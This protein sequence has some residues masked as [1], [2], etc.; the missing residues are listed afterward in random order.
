MP[1]VLIYSMFYWPEESGNGPYSTGL[2]EHLA[3]EGMGVTVVTAMPHYP[4]WQVMPEYRGRWRQTDVRAGVRIERFRHHIP[5]RQSAIRRAMYEGSFLAHAGLAGRHPRPDAVLGVI[6][7]LSGGVLARLAAAR[8]RAA[9][10]IVVQDVMS[11]AAA[12]SGI[13]GGRRV[14]AVTGRIEGW[15]MG[16]ATI[17]APVAA[18]F[19]PF[20]EAMGVD[21]ARIVLLPNWTHLPPPRLERDEVRRELGWEPDD[22]VVLHAGNMGLKQGL[23]QVIEAARTANEVDRRLRF[24]LMGDGNQRSHLEQLAGSLPNVTFLPFVERDRLVE[25]LAAADVLLVS[26]RSTVRDMSLPSK[27]TSYFAAGRPVVAAVDPSGASAAEVHRA[28]GGVVTRAGDASGLVR[29]IIDLDADRDEMQRLGDN[30]RRYAETNLGS[31]ASLARATAIVDRLLERTRE[32]RRV[33]PS[34]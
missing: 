24:V 33:G 20:I 2:A 29:A 10:G 34:V 12:Q 25:V 16:R 4:A 6:P 5:S 1:S 14:A 15:A 31:A 3:A 32:R 19:Q 27:L 17:V 22:V 28:A 9:Y 13:S 8:A 21:P 23:E 18:A 30:S 11:A 26:E 7:S